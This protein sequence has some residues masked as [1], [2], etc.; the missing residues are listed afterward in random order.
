MLFVFT[1]GTGVRPLFGQTSLD[2]LISLAEQNNPSL[3]SLESRSRALE[4]KADYSGSLDDLKVSAGYMLQPV[5]TRVG[6]QRLTASVSQSFPWFG[7]LSSKE[8]SILLQA[9]AVRQDRI[10]TRNRILRDITN[11]Y[12]DLYSVHRTERYLKEERDYLTA[13]KAI[14]TS[15]YEAGSSRFSD[16]L[17]IDVRLDGLTNRIENVGAEADVI[18]ARLEELVGEPIPMG[19][20]LPDTLIQSPPFENIAIARERMKS[21][22]PLMKKYALLEQSFEQK[23][24]S[25]TAMGYPM[26]TVGATYIM[27]D[28]RTDAVLSDNGRDAIVFPQVGISLPINRGKY[29]SM[30]EE[31]ELERQMAQQ[32]RQAVANQLSRQLEESWNA[33]EDAQRDITTYQ[34]Q[35]SLLRKTRDI[36]LEE[37]TTDVAG[38][39]ELLQIERELIEYRVRLL[40]AQVDFEHEKMNI[41][42]LTGAE[43]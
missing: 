6:P 7:V 20:V 3:Q 43:E 34:R 33:M 42:Y 12:F 18:H 5:E 28:E 40:D 38:I 25:A 4:A 2:E 31:A 37:Y 1:A 14:T 11:A 19:L 41:R 9:Q 39:D 30:T 22:H 24:Q 27:I 10:N 35:E 23:R 32:D 8:E 13:L 17:R 29:S 36:V 15:R 26:L 16:I 21:A